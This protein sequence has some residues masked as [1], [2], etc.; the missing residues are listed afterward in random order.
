MRN[1]DIFPLVQPRFDFDK[2]VPK[3]RAG[4]MNEAFLRDLERAYDIYPFKINSAYRSP[5]WERQRG[6][7]GT[8][9]H[10]LGKAVDIS[11]PDSITRYRVFD[12][13]RRVGF[14]RFGIGKTFIHVDDDVCRTRPAYCMFL[15]DN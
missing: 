13:L 4:Q 5:E 12:A 6:R 9:A 1:D 11:T 3:C 8:S 2:C 15:E 10:T 7:S 14:V